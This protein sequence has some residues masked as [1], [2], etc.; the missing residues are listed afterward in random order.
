MRT[1]ATKGR[2]DK[3]L[4]EGDF[5]SFATPVLK[6]ATEVYVVSHTPIMFFADEEQDKVSTAYMAELT[7]RL[8][9]KSK[10][11]RYYMCEAH[12]HRKL[13]TKADS[14]DQAIRSLSKW[15]TEWTSNS[16]LRVSV[17][18]PAFIPQTSIWVAKTG[19]GDAFTLVKIA[20]E[21]E[22]SAHDWLLVHG[23][24]DHIITMLQEMDI[25]ARPFAEVAE[26]WR[27][28]LIKMGDVE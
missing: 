7:T 6:S 14:I 19:Q 24:T 27:A 25:H 18:P 9:D 17:V 10:M 28:D 5:F 20:R 23:V 22:S 8:R 26:E 3:M 13:A 2:Q 1:V 12:T 21:A 4:S 11:T 15:A 16:N